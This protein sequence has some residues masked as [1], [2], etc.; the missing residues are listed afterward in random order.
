MEE[1]QGKVAF[2][3]GGASGIGLGQAKVFA[4]EAGM[5]V[6]IADVQKKRLQEA[7]D[8]FRTKDMQVHPMYLDITDRAAYARAADEVEQLFGPVQ[9]LMNTAGVSARGPIEQASYADWDWHIDV[10]LNGVINGIQTFLPRM[11]KHG[12]GGHIVNTASISAFFAIPTAAL[13]TTSKFA[14]RG[15]SESLRIELDK[16]NIGVS[17]LC[18]G[19][20]NTNILDVAVTRPAKFA[21]TGF[22]S[23]PKALARIK[24]L[25]EAGFDPVDLARVTLEAV[26]RNEFWIFPYPEYVSR[27]EQQHEELIDAMNSWRDHPDY[28]RRMK[29]REEQG[30]GKPGTH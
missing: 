20:V 1:L 18:P 24:A 2:I 12:Q 8:Y 17:C 3:T 26:K 27:I 13:Y 10:N 4:E 23:D 25:L 11:I 22:K 28:A 6:V 16:Y 14:L 7:T 29:L 21:Q 19:S 5:K 9:L 15:L 30:Q